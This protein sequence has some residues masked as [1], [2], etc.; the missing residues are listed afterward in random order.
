VKLYRVAVLING[1]SL[2]ATEVS[3]LQAHPADFDGFD[4]NAVTLDQWLRVAAYTQ[5]RNSLPRSAQ[6][7]LDLFQWSSPSTGPALDTEL[8][9]EIV[10]VTGWNRDDVD[11]LIAPGH[12]DLV[13]PAKFRSEQNLVKLQGTLALA[14]KIGMDIDALF[15]WATPGSNFWACHQIAEDIRKAIKAGYSE[16]DWEKVVRPLN[17]ALREH[18][19]QALVDYLTVQPDIQQW[20]FENGEA[21]PDADSLFE[22]FLIDVQMDPCM[23]TSRIK[24]AISTVQLFIQRCLLD[25]EKAHGV[26]SA[27]IDQ[28]RW[29][30]LAEIPALGSQ[31]PGVP[32]SR[33]L[34]RAD[35]ARRQEPV[36][37]RARSGALAEGPR[38]AER[39]GR[40]DRLPLQ[41]RRGSRTC[42]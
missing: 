40:A 32:L 35:A 17:D 29:Q 34:D 11:K 33:K 20:A 21:V 22:F 27:A 14:D 41:G 4:W 31:P 8:V 26:A 13:D 5:L 30:W 42:W 15:R 16:D 2:N 9:A 12:F 39:A 25:Q 23:Q 10:A 28:S 7:L 24:Q 3:Y 36:L 1:F 18:Q 37:Q 38:P 19:R 6:T